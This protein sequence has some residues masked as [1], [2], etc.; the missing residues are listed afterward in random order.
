MTTVHFYSR[1]ILCLLVGVVLTGTSNAGRPIESDLK[2]QL[3][4][5]LDNH[6]TSR[7]TTVT[8]KVIDL[9]NGEVLYDRGGDRL[10]TPASNLKI[11]TSACALD[12]FGPSHQFLTKVKTEGV[13]QGG[14]LEGDLVLVGGGD[15]MLSSEDMAKLSKRVVEELGITKIHGKV[16]IDNSRY[17]SPLK[18][19]GWMW[20]D[21]P[22]YYNMSVTPLMVDFNVLEL[23][24]TSSREGIAAALA[25]PSNYPA[26]QLRPRKSF[27]GETIATRRPFTHPILVAEKGTLDEPQ[28][29]RLTM[30]DPGKWVS[31]VFAAMLM[32][33]GVEF[34]PPNQAKRSSGNASPGELEHAGPTL[35]DTLKHFNNKSENAVGEVLLHEIAIANGKKKPH[36]SDGA[37]SITEWLIEKA[38]LEQDSFKLVDG[39]GLSRYNLISADSSVRLLEFM[40]HHPHADTFYSAL[41]AYDVELAGRKQPL[42]AAKP[43]GMASVSTISGYLKTTSGKMLAFSLLANGYTGSASPVFE[44][45]QKVWQVLAK[46]G[47]P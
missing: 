42:V 22:D 32:E 17:A 37:A 23:Q 21:D 41:P 16:V 27:G 1:V 18:G 31:G 46:D 3:D 15:A 14:V 29:V 35:A 44:L 28:T 33:R 10:L 43:G 45:R 24:L 13:L 4:A 7:Q 26:V 38:G 12:L 39:S 30:H 36:W 19:P 47:E 2:K 8:L 20:D 25:L 5:V 40:H 11:Y 6:S 34:S 9:E